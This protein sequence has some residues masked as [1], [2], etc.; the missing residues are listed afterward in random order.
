[1]PLPAALLIVVTL[2]IAG[3]SEQPPR[4]QTPAPSSGRAVEAAPTRA[5]LPPKQVA[6]TPQFTP[7]ACPFDTAGEEVD[8]GY[9]IVPESRAKEGSPEVRLAVAIVRATSSRKAGDPLVY[10]EGGPGGSAIYDA[11]YWF[12]SPFR[13]RR[14]VIL[15]DQRGTGYSLP[16]LNCP[17]IESPDVYS[18][19][20]ELKAARACSRRLR[21]E[22]VDLKQYNSAAIAADI[23]DL[24]VA[25]GLEEINLLGV[26]YGTRVALTVLRDHPEGIRSVI[27]DSAYPPQVDAY[28]EEAANF[29]AAI[30][31]LLGGCAADPACDE[32]YPRLDRTLYRL[33]DRLNREPALIERTDAETGETYEEELYGD[34]LI[35]YLTG[36]M[37]DTASIPWLPRAIAEAAAGD[38][39]LV[40]ELLDGWYEEEETPEEEPEEQLAAP[41]SGEALAESA[42]EAAID[43]TA[44]D[45]GDISD[46]EGM[47][48]S[49]ECREEV[50]FGDLE[51]AAEAL[52]RYRKSTYGA[53][54][55]SAEQTAAICEV[56]GAGRARVVEER[57]VTSDVPA[58]VLAGQYDPITP[59]RWGSAAAE[60]LANSHL[61]EF[62]G[63]GHGVV[64][65]DACPERIALAFLD[66]P[67]ARPS[68]ACIGRMDGPV[69]E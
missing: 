59:P 38:Y 60:H 68:A 6:Y 16:S 46:S 45:E 48:Y 18:A 20:D 14:D 7:A 11:D 54:L 9:L 65:A 66:K 10:L 4:V 23:A 27:L 30:E 22:G 17:E 63:M 2:L 31:A 39:E 24:R 57:P 26:S 51:A 52:S 15:I 44:A 35:D 41:V 1:M 43:T 12:D 36:W 32:A 8:C 40:V 61:F 25:L 62:P 34:D 33:V 50:I 56:W 67:L 21:R 19:D 55:G 69:F 13:E 53:L 64:F 42:A 29:A 3:C 58:L 37:Y 5:P 47:F 49:V 28:T